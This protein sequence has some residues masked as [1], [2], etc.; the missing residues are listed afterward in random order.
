MREPTAWERSLIGR[1][2][3]NVRNEVY[4]CTDVDWRDVTMTRTNDER[5][6]SSGQI[7]RTWHEVHEDAGGKYSQ[8]GP[9]GH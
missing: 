5:K 8:F 1:E 7:G 6:I 9:V 2:F 3:V 4:E